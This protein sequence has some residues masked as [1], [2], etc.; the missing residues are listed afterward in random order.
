MIGLTLD[1]SEIL[2]YSV[3]SFKKLIKKK[4]SEAAFVEFVS[5]QKKHTIRLF[6]ILLF[7]M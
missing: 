7:Q 4:V 3:N 6:N 5:E 1:E 2:G